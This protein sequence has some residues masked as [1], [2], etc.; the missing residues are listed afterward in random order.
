[1]TLEVIK[2]IQL[3]MLKENMILYLSRTQY[4]KWYVC[5]GREIY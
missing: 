4:S 3:I 5:N 1:M 2:N